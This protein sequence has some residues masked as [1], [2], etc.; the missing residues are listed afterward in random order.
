MSEKINKNGEEIGVMS[1]VLV[2]K[3]RFGPPLKEVMIPIYYIEFDPTPLEKFMDYGRELNAIKIRKGNYFVNKNISDDL[4]ALADILFTANA[5][6]QLLEKI[7][8]EQKK[9][10]VSAEDPEV[11]QIMNEIREGTFDYAQYVNMD[12][13]VKNEEDEDQD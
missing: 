2:K 1:K 11:I 12:G 7:E 9:R 8:D 4:Y 10:K 3:N 5:F 13:E 6:D